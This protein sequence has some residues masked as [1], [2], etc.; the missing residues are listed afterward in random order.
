MTT[1]TE[2]GN[3]GIEQD[4][5]DQRGVR[6]AAQAFNTALETPCRRPTEKKLEINI[7]C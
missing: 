1:A 6:N 2:K 5:G 7:P 3:P 4:G